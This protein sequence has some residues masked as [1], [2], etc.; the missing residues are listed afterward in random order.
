MAWYTAVLLGLVQGLAEFLPIS[1]SGH[2]LLLQHLFGITDGGLVLTVVLHLATLGAVVVVYWR[3]LWAL[4]RHP[5]CAEMGYLILGTAVTC[6]LVLV[7]KQSLESLFGIQALPWLFIVTGVLLLLP[8][9]VQPRATQ[10]PHWWQFVLM[11]AAQGVAVLPGLSRSGL[12]I[13]AGRLSGLP[14]ADATDQ[15][16]LLSIPVI[17]A[18]LVYTV[19]QGGTVVALGWGNLVLAF[20]TAFISGYAALKLMLAGVRK[21]RWGGFALYLF[22]LGGGLLLFLGLGG[23]F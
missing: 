11:G 1:S 7:A 8:G 23:G 20:L 5:L 12:T 14:Q 17:V 13:A 15:S 22:L 19:W 4:I 2:L 3:R 9:L 21:F 18:S 10:R 6:G 16:F